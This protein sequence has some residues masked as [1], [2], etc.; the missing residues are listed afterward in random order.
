MSLLNGM[1][2]FPPALFHIL[3]SITFAICSIN[4]LCNSI[5]MLLVFFL[6]RERNMISR[7]DD[8]L[9]CLLKLF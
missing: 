5:L 7:Q 4:S 6:K 3:Y 2:L 1:C 8:K 9:N